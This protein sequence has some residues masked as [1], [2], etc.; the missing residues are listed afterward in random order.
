VVRYPM[1]QSLWTVAAPAIDLGADLPL[2]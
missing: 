1:L 2:Q